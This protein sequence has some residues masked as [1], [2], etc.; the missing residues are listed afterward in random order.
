M[1]LT[2][3]PGSHITWSSPGDRLGVQRDALREGEGSEPLDRLL[4]EDVDRGGLVVGASWASMRLR[5]RRS[6]TMRPRRSDSRTSCSA[7]RRTTSTS[8]AEAIVS[9]RSPNAP[10]GVFSSW[11]TLATKSRR[12]LSTRRVSVTSWMSA[13][14]PRTSSPARSGRARSTSTSRAAQTGAAPAPRPRRG[15]RLRAADRARARRGLRRGGRHGSASPPRC[16]TPPGRRRRRRRRRPARSRGR[17]RA[18]GTLR[19][20]GRPRR[21]RGGPPGRRSSQPNRPVM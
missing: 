4:H 3:W 2:S 15:G 10:S 13:T 16:E 19:C 20:P 7:R 9:A 8:S 1:A 6:S 5:S 18:D 11:L 17:G 12:M 21:R 14:A